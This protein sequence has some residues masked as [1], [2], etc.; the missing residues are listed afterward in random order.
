MKI[1]MI[2]HKRIPSREGGVEIVVEELA[3]RMVR[4]GHSVDVYNRGGHH[5]SG[6]E[7]GAE[8]IKNY[9]GIRII[10]IPTFQAKELNALVYSFL[11]SIRALFGGYDII[12][13]HASGPCAMIWIPKL[14]GKHTVATLHGIDS[15]RSKWGGFASRYLRFGEKMAAVYADELIVLSKNAQDYIIDTY[16]RESHIIPNGI[17]EPKIKEADVI[18]KKYGLEK[19]GYLLFLSRIVPEKGLHYVI[20]A[21]KEI[22]TD[23][24]LV[25]AG[26]T[27]HSDSYVSK[28]YKLAEP[29]SRILFTGFVQGSELEELFSNAYVYVMPSDLEGMPIS[30]LEAMSYGNCCLVSDIPEN[31][32]IVDDKALSFKKSDSKDLKQKLVMLINDKALTQKYKEEAR[33]Y[34]ISKYNWEEIVADTLKLYQKKI[35]K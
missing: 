18:K 35:R 3:T 31:I 13:F 2:G 7:Y 24:K 14:F 30:L 34:I 10:T 20:E 21:Y 1:A 8:R 15:L 29:D 33:G 11:A 9:K 28:M 23:L 17:V 19:D 25:V 32:E 12:H 26:G 6:K 4:S 16:E 5:V 27:S 22:N